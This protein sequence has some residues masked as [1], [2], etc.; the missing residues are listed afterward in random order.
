[1]KIQVPI[2]YLIAAFIVAIAILAIPFQS[3]S[4]KEYQGKPP[5]TVSS[6][7]PNCDCESGGP[8][9]CPPGQCYC[10]VNTTAYESARIE[11]RTTGKTMLVWVDYDCP[12][13]RAATTDCIHFRCK[14]YPTGGPGVFVSVGGQGAHLSGPVSK[15]EIRW[16]E[17]QLKSG[18]KFVTRS[19][20]AVTTTTNGASSYVSFGDCSTG[21]CSPSGSCSTTFGYASPAY[22]GG[23]CATGNCGGYAGPSYVYPS[24]A[25]SYQSFGGFGGYGGGFM[26]Y[27]GGG[28]SCP[29]CR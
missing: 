12:P 11:H 10:A 13:C 3:A 9:I 7:N 2:R 21:S 25:G 27:G 17:T 22:F 19:N 26:S 5:E 14:H 16:V 29:T 18:A 15:E 20:P 8:C 1:M 23:G 28:G 24:Y 4:A 6:S